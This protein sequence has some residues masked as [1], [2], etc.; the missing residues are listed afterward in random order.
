MK[1][2]SRYTLL[3]AF[4]GSLSTLAAAGTAGDEP[5]RR[6]VHFTDLD[7]TRASGAR[8]LYQRIRSAAEE[9]CVPPIASDPCAAADSRPCIEAAIERAV[10]DVNSPLLTDYYRSKRG[11]PVLIADRQAGRPR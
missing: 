9:V 10:S 4:L 3:A 11:P 1:S 8:A 2:A 7:L 6:T 5:T